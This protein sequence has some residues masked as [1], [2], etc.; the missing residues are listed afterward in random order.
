M[1]PPRSASLLPF[2]KFFALTDKN[3]TDKKS[4]LFAPFW[5]Y[6]KRLTDR[7]AEE[8]FAFQC[9]QMLPV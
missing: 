9:G 7:I 4:Y 1:R 5:C 2:Q 8:C 6:K 3:L